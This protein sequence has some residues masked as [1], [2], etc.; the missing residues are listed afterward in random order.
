MVA[1]F[2]LGIVLIVSAL[3]AAAMK[4]GARVHADGMGMVI[5]AY[6]LWYILWPGKLVVTQALVE[7]HL[8]AAV[9]QLVAVPVLSL[10]AWLLAG[11][12]GV[13]LAWRFRAHRGDDDESHESLFVFDQLAEAAKRDG[14]T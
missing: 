2:F 1:F 3:L 14:F 9:W 11:A 12:P 10:P 4:T 7:R 5:S 6:E 8:H 13:F